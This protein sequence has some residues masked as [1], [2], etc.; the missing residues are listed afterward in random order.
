MTKRE[1]LSPG[2]SS[3]HLLPFSILVD[4]PHSASEVS[5]YL[6]FQKT[7]RNLSSTLSLITFQ[8][9]SSE[10][11]LTNLDEAFPRPDCP[12]QT[13]NWLLSSIHRANG[14]H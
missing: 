13:R 10:F 9:A 3:E 8:G 5:L 1:T 14:A 12:Y 2:R 7:I 6:G 4:E 11:H